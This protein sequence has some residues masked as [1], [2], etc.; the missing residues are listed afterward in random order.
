MG[1]KEREVPAAGG[2]SSDMLLCEQERA[3]MKSGVDVERGH[4]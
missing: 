1:T 2:K 3:M 4:L